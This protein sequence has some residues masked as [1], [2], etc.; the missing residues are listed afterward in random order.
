MGKIKNKIA[1]KGKVAEKIVKNSS[2]TVG[3]KNQGFTEGSTTKTSREARSN[4]RST[5]KKNMTQKIR[6]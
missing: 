2:K 6:P 5:H 3:R 1:R 4:S